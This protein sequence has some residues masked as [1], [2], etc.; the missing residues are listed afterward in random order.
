M[1]YACVCTGEWIQEL[2]KDICIIFIVGS[3]SEGFIMAR[4]THEGKIR[5]AKIE[6]K[7][8]FIIAI[9]E[10]R[11][12]EIAHTEDG[13]ALFEMLCDGFTALAP[14]GDANEFRFR[15]AIDHEGGGGGDCEIAC[16]GFTEGGIGS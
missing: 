8:L 4:G 15:R 12:D 2:A 14:D 7:L 11:S 1:N 10:F 13:V 9:D 5:R 16:T 3:G 6:L